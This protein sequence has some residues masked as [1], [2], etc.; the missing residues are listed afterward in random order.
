MRGCEVIVVLLLTASCAAA[1]SPD[2]PAPAPLMDH[3]QHLISPSIARLWSLSETVTAD[4]LVAQLDVAG[5]R[6]AI[7]L[8]VAYAFGRTV[9]MK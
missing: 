7:V 4:R 8:S 3:H 1:Q 2:V 6:R 9:T 5:I